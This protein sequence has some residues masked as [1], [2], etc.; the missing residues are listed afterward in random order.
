MAPVTKKITEK[1]LIRKTH[2]YE[3]DITHSFLSSSISSPIIAPIRSLPSPSLL[4]VSLRPTYIPSCPS[5]SLYYI[6]PSVYYEFSPFMTISLCRV[7]HYFSQ[8]VFSISCHVLS[9]FMSFFMLSLR[10]F[11]GRLL[12]LLPETSSRSDFAQMWFDSRLKQWPDHFSILFSR[13]VS[14]GFMCAPFLVSSFLIWS[15]LVFPFIH[16][17]IL[18]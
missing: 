7:V 10:L 9:H 15:N 1:W 14:T 12:L 17:A 16:L 8:P 18:I 2:R 13:K 5:H 6:H 11:S 4:S 3:F